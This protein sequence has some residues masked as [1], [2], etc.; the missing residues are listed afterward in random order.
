M[1]VD[2]CLCDACFR[3]VDRRAN[4]P[5]YKKRLS[6]PNKTG[7]LDESK[8]SDGTLFRS[9][10]ELTWCQALNCKEQAQQS[11]CSKW[12]LKMRRTLSKHIQLNFENIALSAFVP[13]CDKH[14]DDINQLL[15]CILCNR[16][17]KRTNCHFIN[18]VHILD[19]Y[20]YISSLISC[21]LL[22]SKICSNIYRTLVKL[23]LSLQ[24][25]DLQSMWAQR[26]LDV[27]YAVIISTY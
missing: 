4:C 12:A 15:I 20:V 14:N 21:G 22:I 2:S 13:I 19:Y 3:H 18:Q 1:T 7:E 17:L 8:E 6:E 10:R 11:V 16:H 25:M 26:P 9:N 5:S 24:T 23:N 27:N